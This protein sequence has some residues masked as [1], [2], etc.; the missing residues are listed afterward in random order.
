MWRL[1]AMQVMTFDTRFKMALP[2][3]TKVL[4]IPILVFGIVLTAICFFEF[5]VIG[6][7][8]FIHFDAP[9]KFVATGTYKQQGHI[10]M[11]ETQCI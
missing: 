3:W 9:K 6:Q 8:T 11:L 1:V 4:A 5:A 7:G 2:G 10:N